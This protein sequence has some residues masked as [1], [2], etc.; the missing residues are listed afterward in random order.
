MKR[1]CIFLLLLLLVTYVKEGYEKITANDIPVK[2]STEGNLSDIAAEVTAIPLETNDNCILRHA[3]QVKKEGRNLFLVNQGKL[4]HFDCTGKFISQITHSEFEYE[5]HILVSDYMIDP[6][7]KQLI[8]TDNRQTAHYYTYDG[9][10]LGKIDIM[11]NRPWASISKLSYYDDSIWAT[12]DRVIKKGKENNSLCLEQW[13]YKLDTTFNVKEAR[14]ITPAGLGRFT[15]GRV[16]APEIAVT[17]EKVYVQ[18]PSRE[19]DQLLRDTLYLLNQ[20]K[21]EITDDYSS[22]LPFR[23]SGRFLIS[24][25]FNPYSTENNYI[26]CYDC[27]KDR[28]YNVKEGLED[29]FYG[30][31]RICD[32]QAM[33]LHGNSYCYSK[34]GKEVQTA[35]PDRKESDN[36]VIFVVKLKA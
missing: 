22:I 21:L 19:P 23:M 12:V 29:N 10:F 30:T 5:N 1:T 15:L 17:N 7:Q 8:V 31:G 14:K 35:F 18:S 34:T 36:P 9:K 27:E 28:A 16:I 24:S 20:N 2:C 4:Y 11:K 26:F 6:I 25:Y 32:L 13:L 3:R 33:D